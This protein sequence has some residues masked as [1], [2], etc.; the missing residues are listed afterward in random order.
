VNE[1]ILL[2]SPNPNAVRPLQLLSHQWN[3]VL[4]VLANIAI[5][6]CRVYIASSKHK[7][8]R[9]NSRQ[10]CISRLEFE[11]HKHNCNCT[12]RGCITFEN[13]PSPECLDEAEYIRKITL[14]FL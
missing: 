9:E 13:S 1:S 8:G 11:N 3:L 2:I 10:F 4:P 7:E 14:L 12:S 6:Y 5:E